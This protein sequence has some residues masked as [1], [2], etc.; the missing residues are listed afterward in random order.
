MTSRP[1]SRSS[2]ARS[3]SPASSSR[4]PRSRN[5]TAVPAASSRA[6]NS[7]SAPSR[8]AA[9]LGRRS[10]LTGDG[11]E[12]A[13]PVHGAACVIDRLEGGTALRRRVAC[14]LR[15]ARFERQCG[16]GKEPSRSSLRRLGVSRVEA[17]VEPALTLLDVAAT[18]PRTAHAPRETQHAVGVP[19]V[20]GPF[21]C[22]AAH[23]VVLSLQ[24]G[25]PEVGIRA[26]K[27]CLGLFH[28]VHVPLAVPFAGLSRENGAE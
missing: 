8:G 21:E 16:D 18:P 24:L 7:A 5:T 28:E 19:H 12:H 6:R 13:C 22:P 15:V 9:C 3:R 4:S 27:M 2:R 23:V 1:S 11:A 17:P 20:E 26:S 25:H 14:P 10:E